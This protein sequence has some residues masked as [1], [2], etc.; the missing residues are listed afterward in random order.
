MTNLFLNLPK[1]PAFCLF[2]FIDLSYS[3]TQS[4]RYGREKIKNMVGVNKVVQGS[5]TEP[6]T[7]V[8]LLFHTFDQISFIILIS[9]I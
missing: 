6:S 8:F 2:V 9:C 3:L 4:S 5:S 7:N 1:I